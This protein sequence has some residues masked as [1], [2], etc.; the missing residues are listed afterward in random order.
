M[1]LTTEIYCLEEREARSVRSKSAVL[2]PSED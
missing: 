2:L 1:A